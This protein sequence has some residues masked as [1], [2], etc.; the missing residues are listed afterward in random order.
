[1]AFLLVLL[2]SRVLTNLHVNHRIKDDRMEKPLTLIGSA[3]CFLTHISLKP[4]LAVLL[5]ANNFI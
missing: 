2:Q 1:M 3:L 4:F 5:E